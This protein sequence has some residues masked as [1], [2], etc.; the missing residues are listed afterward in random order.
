[1]KTAA[2]GE[3]RLNRRSLFTRSRGHHGD[4]NGPVRI[5]TAPPRGC[6]P[7]CC[8]PPCPVPVII[9]QGRCQPAACSAPMAGAEDAGPDRR[10]HQ[11][12]REWREPVIPPDFAAQSGARRIAMR[13]KTASRRVSG[14]H[15]ALSRTLTCCTKNVP[16]ALH[17]LSL[18]PG[19]AD[20]QDSWNREPNHPGRMA[21]IEIMLIGRSAVGKRQQ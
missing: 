8:A 9:Q 13:G 14:V 16:H 19:S 6:H 15:R 2:P 12:L 1:M 7:A 21:G 20:T 4:P 17:S 18:R 3:Q 11:C 5:G 10:R